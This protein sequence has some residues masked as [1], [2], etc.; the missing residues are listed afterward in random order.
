MA[1]KKSTKIV[2]AEVLDVEAEIAVKPKRVAKAK[3]AAAT[4]APLEPD[5]PS[6]SA[7][8]PLEPKP[9]AK[10]KPNTV[11]KHDMAGLITKSK[12]ITAEIVSIVVDS[13][14]EE[15]VKALAENK[16]VNLA[17]FGKFFVKI[18]KPR[19]TCNPQKRGEKVQVPSKKRPK[20]HSFSAFDTTLAN[21]YTAPD[22]EFPTLPVIVEEPS[23][24]PETVVATEPEPVAV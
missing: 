2:A 24:A 3:I 19:E 17:G 1:P 10:P 23:S 11:T 12:G 13:F 4:P 9:A 7:P 15:T 18:T 22:G 21:S 20:F 8:P 14:L 5:V 6:S 16:T